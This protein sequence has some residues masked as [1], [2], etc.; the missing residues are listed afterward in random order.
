M[1]ERAAPPWVVLPVKRFRDGKTRLAGILDALTRAA[2]A[3]ALCEHVLGVLAAC[4]ALA[5]TLVV[6]EGAEVSD[7]A[8]A[9]GA[10]TLLG[11]AS[12]LGEAVELGLAEVARR[13]AGS[14]LVLMADLPLLRPD[15]ITALLVRQA[16][17]D[18]VLVPDQAPTPSCSPC[19]RGS[20]SPLVRRTASSV[21]GRLP[22]SYAWPC[23]AAQDSAWISMI[24]RTGA[25]SWPAMRPG[26]TS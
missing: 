22:K 26:R 14:A 3:R 2:L 21:T 10:E 5:G 1:T 9:H 15:E 24:P 6:T 17:A 4:P 18:L 19:R 7:L 13:G 20:G 12:D 25:T 8:R 23:G 11:A 16:E